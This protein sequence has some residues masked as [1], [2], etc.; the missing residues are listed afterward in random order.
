MASIINGRGFVGV[1]TG[2]V[3]SGPSIVTDGLKL[4]LDAG[5]TSSYPGTGT[6]W[7]DISG[8]GNN[9]TLTNGPTYNSANNGSI[10][11]DGVNDYI[12][13]AVNT[14]QLVSTNVTISVWFNTDINTQQMMI[15]N[16]DTSNTRFYVSINNRSG[17]L[18]CH[19]G[20]GSQQNTSSS[21]AIIS[22]SNWY[23]YIVTYDGSTVKGYLNGVL[24]DTTNIGLQVYGNNNLRIA[25]WTDMFYFKG[26][27]PTLQIYNR[28][29]SST[30][31]LQNYN[32]LKSRYGL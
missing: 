1:R 6:V 14:N 28:P 7:T 10:V 30:E 9:G 25:N 8:N 24:K 29:L 26:K 31:V 11:F 23:N 22:V 12:Q 5:N 19:W 15:G 27:I 16:A 20:F 13:M 4:Y 2:T 17:V 32:A 21:N 18:V 3:S